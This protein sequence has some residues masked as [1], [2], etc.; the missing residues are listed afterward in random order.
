MKTTKKTI[1]GP[2]QEQRIA[3]FAQLQ[4]SRILSRI[5]RGNTARRLGYYQVLRLV[6]A[7]EQDGVDWGRFW[8]SSYGAS[9]GGA[10]DCREEILHALRAMQNPFSGDATHFQLTAK[11]AK[12]LT[13]YAQALLINAPIFVA[14]EAHTA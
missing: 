12:R 7:I 6:S 4:A 2:I 14:T 10:L 1:P 13:I 8:T 11:G 3:C 5:G 9:R